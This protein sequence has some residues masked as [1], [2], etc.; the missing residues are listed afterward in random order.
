ML[1]A[2]RT[3]LEALDEKG[4][5]YRYL[6]WTIGLLFIGGL[7]LG[8]I[9]QKYAF[10][11]LWTGF[12]LGKDLTDNKT[13]ISFLFWLFAWYKNRGGHNRRGWILF[14]AIINLAIYLIPHSMLG[15]ELEYSKIQ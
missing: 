10:G 2:N 1:F 3:A 11:A 13:L 14:A 4:N 6:L 15:S 8:P 5:S 9:M 7:I 12:P